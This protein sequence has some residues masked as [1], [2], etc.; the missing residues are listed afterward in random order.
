MPKR[1][2]TNGVEPKLEITDE[3]ISDTEDIKPKK[4]PRK[5]SEK[6]TNTEA[7]SDPPSEAIPIWKQERDTV[8]HG[9]LEAAKHSKKYL[10]AHVSAQ[11][12]VHNA[13]YNAVSIGCRSFAL[14]LKNQRR[15][16]S[17]PISQK[18]IDL[19]NKAVEETN[20][21]LGMIV[22]HGSYLLNAASP[23]Q[24][25]RDKTRDCLIDEVQRC[26]KLGIKLYNFHPGS[27]TG[28]CSYDEGIQ[29]VAAI[30]DEVIEATEDVIIL[31]ET[32][33]GQKNVIGG[34]FEDLK[35]IIDTV[36]PKNRPRVGV[37]FDTCHIFVG[38]YEVR[39][40]ENYEQTMKK[41]DE[42][43][44][45]EN[46]RAVHLNDSLTKFNSHHDR[47]ANIGKGEMDGFFPLFMN[48]KRFDN[49]PVV[50]ETPDGFYPQEMTLLYKLDGLKKERKSKTKTKG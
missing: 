41:F 14:F 40:K 2:S 21:D 26:Q 12:G 20:F 34:L 4:K 5:K 31:V 35:H 30:L 42:V 43:V 15:W 44:G 33:A 16:E 39:D 11:G 32:M 28:K 19:W 17:K 50:L 23:V 29:Y 49:I 24:E 18:D 45:F 1:T 10:G 13:I 9:V 27:T 37:C 3:P 7:T 38:G 25:Q 47:H 22:P 8:G 6:K 36:K 48:D 46:L